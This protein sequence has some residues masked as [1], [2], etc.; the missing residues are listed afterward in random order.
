MGEERGRGAD[1]V[2]VISI[3]D[4]TVTLGSW[5]ASE[6]HRRGEGGFFATFR[7]G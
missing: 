7:C 5:L 3:A 1:L 6:G 2:S 4:Q